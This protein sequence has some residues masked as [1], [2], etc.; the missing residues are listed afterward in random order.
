[1]VIDEAAPLP[2]NTT[3]LSKPSAHHPSTSK[4]RKLSFG[5][6][7]GLLTANALNGVSNVLP[8]ES[9]GTEMI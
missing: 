5:R 1:M 3:L 9:V 4:L 8:I 2:L 6:L 7:N